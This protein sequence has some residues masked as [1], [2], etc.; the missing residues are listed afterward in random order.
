MKRY[1]DATIGA[2]LGMVYVE[3]E[4]QPTE[5]AQA[6]TTVYRMPLADRN[7]RYIHLEQKGIYFFFGDDTPYIDFF[8]VPRVDIFARDP[9]GG[10][11][12]TVGALSNPRNMEAPICYIDPNRQAYQV[13]NCM[14]DFLFPLETIQERIEEQREPTPDITIFSSA[15]EAKERF[16]F[17]DI[18]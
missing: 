12:G 15:G 14:R 10:Y 13:A 17:I 4:I 16:E 9:R 11:W 7:D 5:I 8:A 2:F 18:R 6:G 1:I 3:E